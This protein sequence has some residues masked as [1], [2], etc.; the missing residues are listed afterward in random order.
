MEWRELTRSYRS[1]QREEK[2]M[3]KDKTKELKDKMGVPMP[4]VRGRSTVHRFNPIMPRKRSEVN[5]DAGKIKGLWTKKSER[6]K[7]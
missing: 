5:P 2:E 4:G 6:K 7:K 1:Q 3:N